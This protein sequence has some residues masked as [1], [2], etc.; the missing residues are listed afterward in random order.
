MTLK[1]TLVEAKNQILTHGWIQR[2]LESAEGYCI[3][4]AIDAASFDDIESFLS[5]TSLV[6][7]LLRDRGHVNAVSSWNDAPHRTEQEVLNLL[8]EAARRA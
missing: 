6:K 3:M 4:G 2:D 1:D 8:D 7:S 5:A